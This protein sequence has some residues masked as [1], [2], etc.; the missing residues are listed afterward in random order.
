VR[1]GLSPALDAACS[2]AMAKAPEDRYPSMKAFAAE[3]L[4][5][6]QPLPVQTELA[7]GHEARRGNDNLFDAATVLPAEARS[8]PVLGSKRQT[9][10]ARPAADASATDEFTAKTK[11]R[12]PRNRDRETHSTERPA[13]AAWLMGLVALAIVVV[14]VSVAAGILWFATK[15]LPSSDH[16]RKEPSRKDMEEPSKRLQGKE[17]DRPPDKEPPREVVPSPKKD[18]TE[19]EKVVKEM[20]T[21]TVQQV[22]RSTVYLR[23]NLPGGTREGSGFFALERGIVITNA[24]VLGMLR[25]GSAL[26]RSIDAVI[27]SGEART[28]KVLGVDLNNDLAVLRVQG[29]VASLPPPLAVDIA[30][31]VSELQKVYIF[32]FPFGAALGKNTT[33]SPTVVTSLRYDKGILKQIQFGGGMHPG[34]DGGPVTDARGVVVGVCVAGIKGTNINFAVP[35]DFIRPVVARAMGNP[36]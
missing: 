34:N 30:A 36:P 19:E 6:M 3:L 26:P 4:A 21:S 29:D 23:V 17:V 8:T 1:P 15:G 16:T 2:K 25:V 18:R 32:G 31:K 33:V 9:V 35:A 20:A 10:H 5:L 13:S 22:K 24:H 27:N 7:A 14:V 12:K 28:G 11:K